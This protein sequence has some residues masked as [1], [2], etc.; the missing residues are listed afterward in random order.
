MSWNQNIDHLIRLGDE[1]NL[2]VFVLLGD[3]MTIGSPLV[4]FYSFIHLFI[5]T[6]I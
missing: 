1:L 2:I 5:F 3:R 4:I 6:Q